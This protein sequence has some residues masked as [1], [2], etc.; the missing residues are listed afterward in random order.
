MVSLL[1]QYYPYYEKNGVSQE[2]LY[3]VVRNQYLGTE[4]FTMQYGPEGETPIP[5]ED[6][7]QYYTDNY[8]RFKYIIFDSNDSEGNPLEGEAKEKLDEIMETYLKEAQEDPSCMDTLIAQYNA[9]RVALSGDN[10]EEADPYA[11]VQVS[12]STQNEYHLDVTNQGTFPEDFLKSI[13][14]LPFDEPTL[15]DYESTK[16]LAIRYPLDLESDSF[17]NSDSM[18]RSSLKG[19]EFSV[20]LEEQAKNY[21]IEYNPDALKTYTPKTVKTM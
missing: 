9:Y 6:I 16:Y 1:Q 2:S 7:Q 12:E 5:E 19:E 17:K 4:L 11:E 10:P 3:A 14:E 13:Q 21:T 8:V 15:K 20:W 18:I